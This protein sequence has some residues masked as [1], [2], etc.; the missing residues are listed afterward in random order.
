MDG[1]IVDLEKLKL[2]YYKIGDSCSSKKDLERKF[3][4][5]D[6]SEDT[7]KNG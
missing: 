3:N 4:F 5:F 1:S 2:S 7:H 6:S